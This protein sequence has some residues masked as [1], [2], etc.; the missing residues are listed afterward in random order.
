VRIITP[1]TLR[2]ADEKG[3]VLVST[4]CS[5]FEA[6]G[7]LYQMGLESVDIRDAERRST[8]ERLTELSAKYKQFDIGV[9]GLRDLEHSQATLREYG[10]IQE[11]MYE[12]SVCDIMTTKVVTVNP[13][14]SMRHA[15]EL[16]RLHRISGMPVLEAGRLEGVI[17]IEDVIK[18]L[19]E[20]RIDSEVRKRM[21]RHVVS[22]GAHERVIEAVRKFSKSGLGRLPVVDESGVLVGILTKGDITGRLITILEPRLEQD[23]AQKPQFHEV[24]ENL[25]ADEATLT[26]RYRVVA[27]DFARAGEGSSKIKRALQS[28]R[29]PAALIR[30]VAISSYEAEMNLVIHSEGGYL[31]AEIGPGQVSI[32]TEDSGPGIEDVEKAM[33]PGFS[34]APDWVRELG[35]GAGVGLCNIKRCADEF[36]LSSAPGQGTLLRAMILLEGE[37]S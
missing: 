2:L 32:V 6:C 5:M 22:I 34:T 21:S 1:E 9:K 27:N 25:L 15:K 3:I 14:D 28:L 23:V 30:R 24:I 35:F 37:Q 36:H 26:L 11:L 10:R 17:S 31:S 33:Q 13:S 16:L 29:V 18:A 4:P 19:E 20:H 8:E 12:L 7:R